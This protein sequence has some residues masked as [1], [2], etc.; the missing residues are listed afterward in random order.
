MRHSSTLVATMVATW[1][2]S[3]WKANPK[4][5]QMADGVAE[6]DMALAKVREYGDE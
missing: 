1:K 4:V 2:R 6:K 5:A 3:T